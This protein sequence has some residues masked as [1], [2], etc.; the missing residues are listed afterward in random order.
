M[1]AT[2]VFCL[3][4]LIFKST[5][6]EE[7]VAPI[8]DIKDG[9]VSGTI[10]KSYSGQEYLAYYGIHFAEPPIGSLRFKVS[11]FFSKKG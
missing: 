10:E 7:K 3:F 8:I 5:T 9:R 4:L 11:T 2:I 1:K 6:Q